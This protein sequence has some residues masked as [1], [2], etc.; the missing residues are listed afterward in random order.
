MLSFSKGLEIVAPG[1]VRPKVVELQLGKIPLGTAIAVATL[2]KQQQGTQ[3]GSVSTVSSTGA[4][5][6]INFNSGDLVVGASAGNP[7]G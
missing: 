6:G 7:N 1:I 2:P 3:S 4:S 5:V